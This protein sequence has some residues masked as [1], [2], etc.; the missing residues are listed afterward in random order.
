MNKDPI[1]FGSVLNSQITDP[2]TAYAE[3]FKGLSPDEQQRVF[4]FQGGVTTDANGETNGHNLMT[5]TYFHKTEQ[6]SNMFAGPNGLRFI[7]NSNPG[8][9]G[10]VP[11]EFLDSRLIV[12]RD[13]EGGPGDDPLVKFAHLIPGLCRT[14]V[15]ANV[16]I[17]KYFILGHNSIVENFGHVGSGGFMDGKEPLKPQ[18]WQVMLAA[19]TG[20]HVLRGV[21]PW[22][23]RDVPG[24]PELGAF[25]TMHKGEHPM[26]GG[27]L[28][29]SVIGPILFNQM[30]TT[31]V[32]LINN[33]E[34]F[35]KQ[36]GEQAYLLTHGL[37]VSRELNKRLPWFR[38]VNQSVL[39][40]SE[41]F[42]RIPAIAQLYGYQDFQVTAEEL[43]RMQMSQEALEQAVKLKQ[44]QI[45]HEHGTAEHKDYASIQDQITAVDEGRKID[46]DAG[47]DHGLDPKG[48]I[49]GP[50]ADPI[51]FRPTD[52]GRDPNGVHQPDHSKGLDPHLPSEPGRTEPH[53][54]GPVLHDPVKPGRR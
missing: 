6:L 3:H 21:V 26:A 33:F 42:G 31:G 25:V 1:V 36:F 9:R 47:Q 14:N 52:P 35:S 27:D 53:P 8:P 15:K 17:R 19:T 4:Y 40:W 44:E 7:M 43:T 46:W 51:L 38:L 29:N 24:H 28:M 54:I 11:D 2:V 39:G 23:Q 41:M 48:I 18:T 12:D 10:E 16:P 37:D 32:T 22:M 49:D 5:I 45:M 34:T 50:H 20:A 13:I 30:F